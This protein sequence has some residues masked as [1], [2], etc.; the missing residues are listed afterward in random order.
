MKSFH[1]QAAA[2]SEKEER[3]AG[4]INDWPAGLDERIED[5]Q[6]RQGIVATAPEPSCRS[7]QCFAIHE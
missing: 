6:Q 4:I 1:R 7:S 2:G 3:V 5:A